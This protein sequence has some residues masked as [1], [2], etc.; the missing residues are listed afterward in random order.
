MLTSPRVVFLIVLIIAISIVRSLTIPP[1][2]GAGLTIALLLNGRDAHLGPFLLM[3]QRLRW[4]PY[5]VTLGRAL[6]LGILCLEE[7]GSRMTIKSLCSG[8]GFKILELPASA[9]L[10]RTC[11]ATHSAGME[12]E[13]IRDKIIMQQPS[14]AA[15]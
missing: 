9:P 12:D 15:A 8:Y 10:M 2:A 14:F 1:M 6:G 3:S 11:K 4:H 13:M 7:Y 5:T